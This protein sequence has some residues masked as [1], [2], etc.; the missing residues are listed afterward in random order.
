[1]HHSRLARVVHQPG[2]Q[3]RHIENLV[4]QRQP[5]A[6]QSRALKHPVEGFHHLAPHTFIRRLHQ[7]PL[8]LWSMNQGAAEAKK[9]V[10]ARPGQLAGFRQ[11]RLLD[12]EV[13]LHH[14]G[15]NAGSAICRLVALQGAYHRMAAAPGAVVVL[16]QR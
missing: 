5:I 3:H 13:S 14:G 12:R 1:M 7:Q 11:P 6:A 8:K 16:K 10:M 15:R 2:F 9:V 4:A